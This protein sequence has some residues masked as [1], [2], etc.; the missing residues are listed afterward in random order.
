MVESWR[1]GRVVTRDRVDTIADGIAVR[2]PIPGDP[3]TVVEVLDRPLE[4]DPDAEPS[5][6]ASVAPIL[7]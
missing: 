5:E 1:A 6:A 3:Q 7:I 2:V 4:R